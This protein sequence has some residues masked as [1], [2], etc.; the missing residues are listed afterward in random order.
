MNGYVLN[1]FKTTLLYSSD[2]ISARMF[3]NKK[4]LNPYGYKYYEE[5]N[6]VK[7]TK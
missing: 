4:I 6:K 5:L 2:V 7:G 3:Y 1:A